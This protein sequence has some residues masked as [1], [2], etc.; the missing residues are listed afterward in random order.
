MP[1]AMISAAAACA[2]VHTIATTVRLSVLRFD[3]CANIVLVITF[4]PPVFSVC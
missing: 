4:H 2:D 1:V 3:I